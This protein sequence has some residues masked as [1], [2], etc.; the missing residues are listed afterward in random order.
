M[1]NETKPSSTLPDDDVISLSEIFGIIMDGK[2][3][4][5]GS[6]ILFAFCALLYLWVATPIYRADALVQ[7]ESKKSPLGGLV[8]VSEALTGETPSEAEI[9]VLRSRFVL[10]EVVRSEKLDIVATPDYFPVLGQAIARRYRPDAD[11][12]TNLNSPVIGLSGFAWGGE[13]IGVERFQVTDSMMG[14]AYTLIAGNDGQYQLLFKDQPVLTGAVGTSATS[15]NQ[16][17]RLFISELTARPGTHFNLTRLPMVTAIENLAKRLGVSEKGKKTGVLSLSLT[18]PSKADNARVLE[19]IAQRYLRQNVERV[20]AEA[21]NS[22]DFLED[23]LPKV[24]ADVELSEG[25]LNRYRLQ[26]QTVD[27]TLETKAV[28]EQ[29]VDIDTQLAQLDIQIQQMGQRYTANHPIMKELQDQK[30][31]L[32]NRKKNFWHNLKVCLKP[33]RMY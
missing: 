27:L 32:L 21:Q 13:T 8:D 24:K 5:V 7:V 16:Q 25:K 6:T 28:L 2:W 29:A 30:Q 31:F 12:S 1:T 20:S 4:I 17:V 3:L 15:A 14:E 11:G 22:L 23:Q 26:N 19:A 33:S 9:E 10:G 18:G